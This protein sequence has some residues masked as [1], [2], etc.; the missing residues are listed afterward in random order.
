MD[1]ANLDTK[2]AM[3]KGALLHLRHPVTNEPLY[4]NGDKKKPMTIDLMGIDGDTFSKIRRENQRKL[5]KK[6]KSFNPEDADEQGLETLAA[7]TKGWANLVLGGKPLEFSK[8]NARKLYSDYPWI[9]EQVNEFCSSREN[10]IK[11]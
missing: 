8:G 11:A 9:R 1:L 6:N 5:S 2:T 4:A 3:E 10:F 7:L